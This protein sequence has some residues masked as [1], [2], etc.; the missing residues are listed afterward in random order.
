MNKSDWALLVL[1]FFFTI[2]VT[3][4]FTGIYVNSQVTQ[5]ERNKRYCVVYGHVTDYFLKEPVENVTIM[6]FLGDPEE[7][8]YTNATYWTRTDAKGFYI[9][10]MPLLQGHE[11][12]EVEAV[13][14]GYFAT[15]LYVGSNQPTSIMEYG[16]IEPMRYQFSLYHADFQM[17]QF[18]IVNYTFQTNNTGTWTNVTPFP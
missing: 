14:N 10:I 8:A 16:Y 13:K 9:E 1:A 18:P 3:A 12:P 7:I 2:L 4:V 11:F 6:F 5:F 15:P 17:V